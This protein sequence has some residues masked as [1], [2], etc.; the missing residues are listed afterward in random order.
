MPDKSLIH[1]D[2]TF[3]DG[4][5]YNKWDF[6]PELVSDYLQSMDALRLDFV[7]IGFRSLKNDGF[8]GGFGFSD[9]TFLC[10]LPIPKGLSKKIGVMINGS[11]LTESE[12]G[13]EDTLET[14]FLPQSQSVITLVRV[15]CH[16]DEFEACLPASTWLKERGYVVGFN[17]MQ[18]SDIGLSEI[19]SLAKKAAE[20]PIDVL[21]FADSLGSLSPKKVKT[22]S[23]T[24]QD[25]WR[26]PLG[27]HAH[28]NQGQAIANTLE[29][30]KHGVQWV[31]STVTG[32]GRGPGN[33]QT[34]YLVIA[35]ENNRKINGNSTKLFSLIR[36]HFKPMQNQFGWG[37][38]PY[39]FMAGQHGIH[40]TYIQEML[41]DERYSD[42]DIISVINYLKVEGGK[43]FSSNKLGNALQFYSDQKSGT[44]QPRSTIEGRSVLILGSGPGSLKHSQIIELFIRRHN[45]YVMALNTQKS[46]DE[47]LIDARA[48][49]HP[50]RLLADIEDYLTLPQP[51]IM[52]LGSL[53]EVI[54]QKL[55][56]KILLDFGIKTRDQGFE[57]FES[58]A[59]LPAS[60]VLA[61]TLAIATSGGAKKIYLAGFDGY[62]AGDARNDESKAI[63]EQYQSSNKC[64]ELISITPTIYP[65]KEQSAY[66]AMY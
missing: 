59:E 10:S 31:D 4:G 53:P 61:Y 48:A 58:H 30:V 24:F 52:P 2:C 32:M 50:V 41:I 56:S 1:I 33:A 18:I 37:T 29:A 64:V 7:E 23:K 39:Y 8:K 12:I 19:Q 45:S 49:C 36:N 14:L 5:Y 38:N 40:P 65:I 11:E 3:R 57:F 15:A 6:P 66:G 63:F 13:L 55:E 26:G 9:E 27:I 43:K 51:L 35:L 44:W 25:S 46:I 22:I 60:M 20:Y 42:A 16:L 28:D 34:E 54:K 21:Y 17:L 62:G 47:S